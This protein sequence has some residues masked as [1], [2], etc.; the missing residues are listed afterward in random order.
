MRIKPDKLPQL[1]KARYFGRRYDEDYCCYEWV[2][3]RLVKTKHG[4]VKRLQYSRR[5][6]NVNLIHPWSEARMLRDLATEI[7]TRCRIASIIRDS[8][9]T[10]FLSE[11]S[12]ESRRELE[13]YISHFSEFSDHITAARSLEDLCGL[14]KRS[15]LFW[16]QPAPVILLREAY[17]LMVSRDIKLYR[18]HSPGIKEVTLADLV[19]ILPT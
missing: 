10:V 11:T 3:G 1:D 9:R 6:V 18:L 12:L 4:E 5:S 19:K 2:I 7:N 15:T 17:K 16:W 14:P 8:D 13:E